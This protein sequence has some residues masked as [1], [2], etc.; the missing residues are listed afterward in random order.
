MT[1]TP[2]PSD[3]V[4]TCANPHG[5]AMRH[6]K[7]IIIVSV[8][9]VVLVGVVAAVIA[10]RP[11]PR[12]V[13]HGTLRPLT[14]TGAGTMTL[15]LMSGAATTDFSGQLSSMGAE[16]GYDNLTFRVTGASTFTYSGTRT[17]VA[18]D[19]NKLFSSI[20]GTGTFTRTSA[21]STETDTIT[22]GTG[23]LAGA[24]GTYT[25]TVTS[26]VV[27]ATSASQ[28]S[29]FTAVARGQIRY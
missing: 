22:G 7:L 27:S 13:A 26:V 19:G 28:T 16:T 29:H 25:D 21:K 2:P 5:P 11:S 14:G 17:F 24:T 3:T 10:L 15:N 23:R 12:P 18:A 9:L 1:I 8:A 4:S 6:G 20:S